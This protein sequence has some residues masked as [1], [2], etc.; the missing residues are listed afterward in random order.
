[1]TIVNSKRVVTVEKIT[2][3]DEKYLQL[4]VNDYNCLAVITSQTFN[5]EG[6]MLNLPSPATVLTISV[7]KIM[8]CENPINQK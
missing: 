6:I 1:M 8:P 2:Q 3:I 4:D 5:S 7:F